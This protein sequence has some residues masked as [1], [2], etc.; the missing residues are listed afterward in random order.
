LALNGQ[1]LGAGALEGGK[2]QRDEDGDDADDDEQFDRTKR[3]A[4]HPARA[5]RMEG[6][7]E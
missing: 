6:H 4:F 5:A 3:C 2:K 7:G 1:G